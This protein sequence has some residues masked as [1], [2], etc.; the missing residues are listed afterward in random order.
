MDYNVLEDGML[1]EMRDLKDKYRMISLFQI[2]EVVK[3]IDTEDGKVYQGL[4]EGGLV[5]SGY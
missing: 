2:S 5:F 1:R 3:I 4:R